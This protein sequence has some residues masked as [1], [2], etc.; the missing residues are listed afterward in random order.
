M[1]RVARPF[2]VTLL[3]VLHVLQGVLLFLAGIA[4]VALGELL[5]LG[6]FGLPHFLRGLLAFV[7]V[8]IIVVA[9][10]YLGLAYGLWFG[11]GWAWTLSLILAGL[12]IIGSLLSLVR[13]GFGSFVILILDALIIYYLMRPN[14]KN[15]FGKGVTQSPSSVAPSIQTSATP[16]TTLSNC[17][18]CGAPVAAGEKFCSHCGAPIQ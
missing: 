5:R 18:T 11:K 4:L 6:L 9:L 3:A 14:V 7:G 15:Y 10:L 17:A 8:A 1:N 16:V 2:G 12:G 13:G